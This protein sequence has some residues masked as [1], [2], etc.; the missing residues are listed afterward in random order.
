[1]KK[2]LKSIAIP[3]LCLFTG[4]PL[5]QAAEAMNPE[6]IQKSIVRIIKIKEE[7]NGEISYGTGTG[8]IINE[9]GN[10][11]TN[12]HVVNGAEERNGVRQIFAMRYV[13]GETRLYRCK[14]EPAD[15][16]K[17]LDLAVLSSSIR[18]PHLSMNSMD[19]KATAVV[20]AVGFP[21]V[22]DTSE[23]AI[24]DAFIDAVIKNREN[25]AVEG[26]G[27][28]I[29]RE[30]SENKRLQDMVVPS[31]STG[32]VKRI[33][34]Q[35]FS[36]GGAPL[37]VVDCDLSIAHGNSGGPLLD[38]AGFVIGVVGDVK[39]HRTLSVVKDENGKQLPVTAEIEQVNQVIAESEL[40]RFLKDRNVGIHSK[41][42]DISLLGHW[43]TRQKILVSLA[44]ACAVVAAGLA[45]FMVSRRQPAPK[46][47][48]TVVIAEKMRRIMEEQ[49]LVK[50]LPNPKV[51]VG[52]VWEFDIQGPG[53][54]SQNVRLTDADFKRGRGRVVLGRNS[55]FSH[56]MVKHDSVSRQHLHFELRD[57]GL[58]VAD[59][60]SSNG[61]KVNGRSLAAPFRNQSLKE[62]DSIQFGE[63]TASV[64]RGF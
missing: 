17:D 47:T 57:S 56:V 11:I 5:L 64:R 59:R 50:P 26:E 53:G 23:Q 33:D 51:R 58:V 41:A 49:G 19:P 34:Y 38:I 46:S 13:N 42:F 45:L 37:K 22:S 27:V 1:M 63:L 7:S 10:I 55:D 15:Q 14:C 2:L 61:T 16:S 43:N 6:E 44:S 28:N 21:G 32:Q 54:F 36:E 8:F 29:G 52:S 40:E 39:Q 25:P 4:G 20:H 18:A 62:G 3:L 12:Q 35:S 60:H 9:S 31:F 48:P 30:M 24:H